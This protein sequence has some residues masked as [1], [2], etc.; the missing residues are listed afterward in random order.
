MNTKNNNKLD[1]EEFGNLLLRIGTA[2][3][4]SGASA[5]RTRLI[6]DRIS[7]SYNMEA[8]LFITHRALTL[9][10]TEPVTNINYSR[11]KRSP[12]QG[13]NYKI[14]SGISRMS[15]SIKESNWTLLQ[16]ADELNRLESAPRHN[17]L[18]TLSAVGIADACFCYFIDGGLTAMAV[19]FLATFVGLFV[20]QEAHHY[21]FNPY[22]CVFLAS[23][24]ATLIAG[25]FRFILPEGGFEAAFASC[26][27][28]LIPG[29]PLIN[30]SNDMMDGNILNGI[31]RGM[32]GL[33]MAFMIALGMIISITIYNF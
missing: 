29:V 16:I 18:L 9:T 10:V 5:A 30:S 28:F 3:M 32:N 19:A 21:R 8:D 6:T 23:L 15:W 2:L 14:V 4:C 22:L 13:V 20:R 24:T 25:A 26:V 31:I 7:R 27:L 12:P 1:I 17:R 11:I 33:I